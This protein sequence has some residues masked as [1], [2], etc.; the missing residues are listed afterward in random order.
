VNGIKYQS[1]YQTL[2]GWLFTFVLALFIVGCGGGGGGDNSGGGS[3]GLSV[4]A[5]AGDIIGIRVGTTANLDGSASST[6]SGSLTYKW[7]FTHKPQASKTAVLINENSVNPTFVPDVIGTYRVQLVVSAGGINSQ[8]AIALIEASTS[9]NV[10]GDVRVHTSFP[11]QCLNC[12]DGRF[13]DA[14]VNP[15]IILPKS[16]NHISTTNMCQACHTTFGFKLIRYVDH[17]EVFG[18]C[19]SCHDGVVA[20][21]KSQFHVKTTAECSDCH[22]TTSFLELDASGNYDHTGIT[23]GCVNCH[24]GKTAIGI[25]HNPDTFDKSNND[26]VFCHNTTTFTG[27]FPDHSNFKADGTR[28]DSCHGSTAQ[29]VKLDHPVM[30]V[31]GDSGVTVDCGSCH[32]VKQ[33]SLGGVY[34]HRINTAVLRCDTC[35]TDNNSIN[36]IGM[37]SYLPGHL[38]PL[39]EDCGAC[40]G[41]GGGSFKNAVINHSLDS[42]KAQRC[43]SCHGSSGSAVSKKAPTHIPTQTTPTV[44]DCNACHTP[45]NFTTGT[46]DHSA[47]N[48]GTLVCSDCHNGTN[49]AGKHIAHIPTTDECNI[50]HTTTTFIGATVDHSTITNNC[51][52]CHDGKISKGKSINHLTTTRDCADCHTTTTPLTF[53]GGT[54]DHVGVTTCASCHDGVIAI[55]K[56]SK[57]NHIPA[58]KECS[59]CHSDTTVPGGF[60]N[61]AFL[62][63]VHPG[64]S[65]GCEGCHTPKFLSDKPV[66]LK[67]LTHVPTSQ[68][69]HS[70]HSNVSFADKTQFTHAGISGNCE[71]CH[72]GNYFTSANAMGKAQDPTPP[73]PTTTADCGTCHGIGNNFKD[74][75]FDHT[76]VV[77]GCSTCH[78]DGQPGAT[79]KKHPAH[80]TTAEDCSVCHVPGTFATA[81]FSHT[82]IVDNC[83]SCHDG[84]VPTATI[85]SINHLPTADDCSVCHNTTAF[86]GARFDHKGSVS[87]C[88]TCHDG[89]IA[90]GKDGNHVPTGEDCS[91][92]HKTTGFIPG[93]F[94]HTG[95]VDN[96]ASCHDGSLAIGK[97]SGHVDTLADC[98]LCHTPNGFIP[99]TFDHSAVSNNTRCDSCH[100]VTSTGKDT[101][102]NPAHW[103]TSFDCRSCHTTSTFLGA[104]WK[105]DSNSAGNCDSCH[106]IAGGAK[107]KPKPSSGHISTNL[108]CD[109]CHTTNQW[110]PTNFVHDPKGNYPGDHRRATNCIDCHGSIV[111]TPFVYRSPPPLAPFCAGCHENDFEPKGDHIGGKGG[112]VLQNRNCGNSGCHK[113]GDSAFD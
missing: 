2:S 20:I 106:S 44:V 75:I 27:A 109:S 81:V 104:S 6:T 83:A 98:G 49:T 71:S 66:L 91:V 76:G 86:V 100:G 72:D 79:T 93:T 111:T 9:G 47:G 4:Q 24:N 78:G 5:D 15:G 96:C 53:V 74:G 19:S 67:A 68:D 13:S 90:L 39:G 8:R 36:A 97:P 7:S 28:C 33:F 84:S 1:R 87:N 54:F 16:G 101:K 65:T 94:D 85:K 17:E 95:I 42:V 48:I 57:A 107:P 73:H 41:V 31:V 22:N 110:A 105:H 88:T 26:C 59:Q 62:T 69:C 56:S 45:G 64:L 34:N 70:C 102:T 60:F 108:Q 38:D 80:V 89:I 37:G 35:H 32:S 52:S 29:G 10:T 23:S 82:G 51:A 12:H 92:C 77:D 25:N 50:C 63:G 30:S 21:G 61:S 112:T 40:H 18:N 58:K 103:A 99:A 55:D 46:F 113:T 3:N 43:D 14:N 11:S